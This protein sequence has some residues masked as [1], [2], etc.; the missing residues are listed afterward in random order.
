MGKN[1]CLIDDSK[2]VRALL[3][4]LVETLGYKVDNADEA[5]DGK[6]A[7]ALLTSGKAYDV[8]FLDLHMPEMEGVE[9]LEAL[10]TKGG[11]PGPI[12]VVSTSVDEG[13]WEKCK[14]LG[15]SGYVAKPFTPA[16]MGEVLIKVVGAP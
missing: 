16:E 6:A 8:V 5:G 10:G 7:L 15:A 13:T 3:K 14:S 4:R 12:V 9:V 2:V 1:I 11:K